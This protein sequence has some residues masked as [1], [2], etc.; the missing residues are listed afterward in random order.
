MQLIIDDREKD[1]ERVRAIKREFH[2]DVIMR[3][4]PAGDILISQ[5]NKPD[6]LGHWIDFTIKKEFVNDA[7]KVKLSTTLPIEVYKD[8]TMDKDSDFYTEEKLSVSK[9]L[10]AF[11]SRV[12]EDQK[13]LNNRYEKIQ[14]VNKLLKL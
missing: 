3:R 6:I 7:G 10:Q 11:S 2:S 1:D 5:D 8:M 9:V 13:D 12:S 14:L 4:L